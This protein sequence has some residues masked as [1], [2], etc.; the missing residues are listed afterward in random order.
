MNFKLNVSILLSV[1]FLLVQC[2]TIDVA[3]TGNK[4]VLKNVKKIAVINFEMSN[5]DSR[6]QEYAD[7]LGHQFLK[8]THFNVI[9]RDKLVISKVIGEQTLSRSGIIDESTAAQMGKILGVDAI[10][11]AKGEPLMI[12]NKN[13]DYSLNTFNIKVIN[14]ETGNI[15]VNAIK[16]PGIAW[17][18]LTRIKYILGLGLIWNKQDMLLETSKINFLAETAVKNIQ[19]EIDSLNQKP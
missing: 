9:E 3:V 11:I 18:P 8:S 16:E 1:L 5:R 17:T 2:S 15:F 10:V 19:S 7:I 13:V 4:Q 6:E 14:V 12:D